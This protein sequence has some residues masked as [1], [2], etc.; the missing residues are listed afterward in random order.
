M[1]QMK[2]KE[3]YVISLYE[4]GCT[5]SQICELAKISNGS[6]YK[7]L[8]INKIPL[9]RKRLYSVD[10]DFFETINTIEKAYILGFIIA[11]GHNN[12]PKNLLSI[13]LHPQDTDILEKINTAMGSTNPIHF[14]QYGKTKKA[15]LGIN[16]KQIC[17][18]LLNL[19]ITQ[20][21]TYDV[22]IPKI[23]P[24]L[25][26]YLVLGIF[27]G[28]G[29][30][31]IDN[32]RYN[33]GNLTITGTKEII[34]TISELIKTECNVNTYIYERHKERDN[35]NYTLSICGN[36]QIIRLLDWLYDDTTIFLN[37]KYEK[38]MV[39]KKIV[40]DRLNKL[41]DKVTEKNKL[42]KEKEDNLIK[43][44]NK[45]LELYSNNLSIRQIK[46]KTGFD[47]R[48]ISKII[49]RNE[50]QI[51]DKSNYN[52]YRLQQIKEYYKN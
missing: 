29:S 34:Q 22:I 13:Q 5:I 25:L 10:D 16:S 43:I 49:K 48:F 32:A 39:L 41:E 20:N 45:I 33:K 37:R 51:R 12:I 6:V 52:D 31:S 26:K 15:C 28:D 7:I 47:R 44:E 42:I 27:D 8:N 50:I 9:N 18:D 40:T 14:Y 2:E 3:P 36:L 46:D 24:D 38:Y 21:K 30:I 19:G 23:T 35:N 17:S 4:S 1:S 11:D